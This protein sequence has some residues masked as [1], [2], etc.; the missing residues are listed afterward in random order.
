LVGV[1]L[2]VVSLVDE[3]ALETAGLDELACLEL[4]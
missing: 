3:A 1:V 2:V 4:I